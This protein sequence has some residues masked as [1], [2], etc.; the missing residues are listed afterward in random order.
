M[1]L[2]NSTSA[3]SFNGNKMITTASGGA[4]ITIDQDAWNVV[5]MY[6]TRYRESYPY[7]QH[8]KMGYNYH[9]SNICAGIGRGQMT[10]ADEHIAHNKHIK[11]LYKER[12]AGVPGVELHDNPGLRYD[13]DFWLNTFIVDPSVRIIGQE[14]AY[15]AVV[16][17]A[18]GGAAGVICSPVWG[19]TSGDDVE[20]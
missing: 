18:A 13:S 16:T 14:N 2:G 9:M 4:L 11:D 19:E 17:G 20:V 8:E 3:L 1:L 7:Y 12:L 6:A 10:V 5:M 15:K